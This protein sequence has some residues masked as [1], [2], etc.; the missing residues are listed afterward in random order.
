MS[1]RA[2]KAGAV[3]FLPKPFN[4]PGSVGEHSG[5]KIARDRAGPQEWAALQDIQR[6]VALLTPRESDVLALVAAGC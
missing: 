4:E 2:M 1:V 5:G 6:R 3:D